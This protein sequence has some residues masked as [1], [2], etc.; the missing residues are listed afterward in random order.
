MISFIPMRLFGISS[1]IMSLGG[2]AIAVGAMVD[3]AIVVVEQTHK[4]LELW[5]RTGRTEDYH[6]VVIDAVKEVGGPS[7]F[8]LLVIAVSFLPVLTLE[9]QEGR[10]F[11]PLAYTKNF[12]MI[13]AA[14]ARDHAGPGD[15]AAVHARAAVLLSSGVAGP[16]CQRHAGRSDPC[17]GSAPDQPRPHSRVRAGVPMVAALEVGGHRG[18]RGHRRRDDP[19]L[20]APW[21][22]VHATA[23][24]RHAALHAV[25]AAWHLGDGGA[26][27]PADTGPDHQALPR[28]RTRARQGRAGR[29]LHRS[30]AA[31]D[32]GDHDRAQAAR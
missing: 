32:D 1:N 28:G 18:R 24:R 6:R 23:R 5:D 3:A 16:H 26:A 30:G 9:A 31:L 14:V 29:D 10:L 11:R 15:A 12:S 7:F 21:I 27:S 19:D 8:A 25:D 2:I 22:R 20:P 13:V 4:K 17:G